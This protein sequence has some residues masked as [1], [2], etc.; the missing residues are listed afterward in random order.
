MKSLSSEYFPEA[1]LYDYFCGLF[2]FRFKEKLNM[3]K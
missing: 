1:F 2:I 3:L